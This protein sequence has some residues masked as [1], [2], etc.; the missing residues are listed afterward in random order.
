MTVQEFIDLFDSYE[1][2]AGNIELEIVEYVPFNQKVDLCR[3]IIDDTTHD[4][5]GD[6]KMNSAFRNVLY[7]LVLINTYTNIDIDFGNAVEE[8][9]MLESRY[10]FGFILSHINDDEIRRFDEIMQCELNDLYQNE[11]SQAAIARR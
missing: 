8:F 7:R 4:K 10:A 6:F 2:D 11:R 5:N 1:G 3:A 9:D